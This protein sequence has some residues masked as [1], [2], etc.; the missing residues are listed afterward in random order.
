LNHIP[1]REAVLIEA[2]RVLAKDGHILITM[3]TPL[4]SKMAHKWW[5]LLK[6]GEDWV[7]DWHEDEV[8]GFNRRQMGALLTGAGLKLTE[9]R[10]FLY[11]FNHL[12]VARKMDQ[13][14]G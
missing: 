11:G 10:R 13:A 2:S 5:E 9:H 1:N 6:L 3:P 12:Y 4:I 7:R 14:T 8:Y